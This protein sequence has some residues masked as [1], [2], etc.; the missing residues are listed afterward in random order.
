MSTGTTTP[1][2]WGGTGCPF[3]G[4]D[5]VAGGGWDSEA[6]TAWQRVQC[7]VCGAKWNEVYELAFAEARLPDGELG[8]PIPVSHL[9][10]PQP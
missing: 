10:A 9:A 2:G 7:D 5:D 6:G 8:E 3:C 1:D 4:S